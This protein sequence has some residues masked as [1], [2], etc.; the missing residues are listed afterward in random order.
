MSVK[1]AGQNNP[2]LTPKQIIEFGHELALLSTYETQRD[3]ILNFLQ[4]NFESTAYIW[5]KSVPKFSIQNNQQIE[6][7]FDLD[8][9]K[10]E[11]NAG[12]LGYHLIEKN[13]QFWFLS[14]LIHNGI[15]FGKLILKRDNPFDNQAVENLNHISQITAMEIYATLQAQL[16][17]W[18]QKQLKLVRN[19]TEQI[20]LITDLDLL[21][22]QIT[23]LIQQTFN[24]SYVAV[25]LIDKGCE[26]LQFMASAL[27]DEKKPSEAKR[28]NFE[29][30]SHPGFALGEHMI[31]H[32]AKTGKEL[33]ANNVLKEPRYKIVDS[34]AETQSEAV[35][36]LKFTSRILG[37]FDVQSDETNAFGENDLLVLRALADNISIAIERTR[38]YQGVKDQADQ[39]AAVYDVSRAITS[40]LN[41]DEL[42]QRIVNLIHERF[43]FP[44]VH[45]FVIDHVQNKITYK[46]GSGHR[47]MGYAKAGVSFDVTAEKGILPWVV[48]HSETMLI[49][50]IEAEPLFIKSYESQ[51][52]TGS[53]MAIP[54][55][56]GGEILGVLD[57]QS[58]QKDAFTYE[59]Q[60]LMETLSDNIAIALRNAGLY[61]SENW[62]RKVAESLRDVAGLLSDNTALSDIL[63]VILIRLR[64]NLPCDSAVFWLFDPNLTGETLPDSQELHL[65]AYQT[66]EDL[67]TQSLEE[68]TY[69]P[70]PWVKKAIN[71]TSPTIRQHDDVIG[72]I[73]NKYHLPQNYSAI[74]APL[75]TGEEIL[76][77]L[78]LMHRTPG[79]YGQE[80]QKITSAFASYAAIAIK[81][82]RL[83]TTSQEQAWIAT[84]LLQVATATQSLTKLDELVT[85]IVRLTPMVVGVKG[86]A[87]FLREPE[88]DVF[89]L[90]AFYGIGN[91]SEGLNLDRPILLTTSPILEKLLITQ[92]PQR[93]IDPKVDFDLPDSFTD[94]MSQDSLMLLPLIVR[95]EILGA[96]MLACEPGSHLFDDSSV[97]INEEQY[98]IIQGIIQQTAIAI[99]NIRLLEAKQEEAYI[100]TVLLQAAQAAVSS[101]DLRDTLESIVHIMPI[102]VGIDASVIYIWNQEENCFHISHA[103]ISGTKDE[104]EIMD[105][106]YSPGDFPMLDSVFQNNHPVVFPFIDNPLPPEDWDLALPDEE[107]TDPTP[108][109]QSRY[110]L[111]MGFP[112]SMKDDKFG[113]LLA[114]DKSFSA[115]RERRF[116]LLWGIAQQASLAI[117]NDIIKNEMIERQHLEREFQL[118]REIQQTFLPNQKPEIPGWEMDVRWET[119]RLVGG[120]FY[121]YFLLPDGRLA[122]LIADVSDKGLAA[123]LYMTV[124]RTLIRAAAQESTSPSET[125]ERVNDL[126]LV[127]SQNG[128]FVTTFYG[129][130]SMEDGT[131]KYTIAGHNPPFLIKYQENEVITFSK[132]GIALGALPDIKLQQ[133]QVTLDPGDCLILYTDG[134]TEAF[135]FEDQMYGEKR[136]RQ[137]LQKTVG[138]RAKV[139]LENLETDLNGFRGSAPLS[140][141]TTMLAISRSKSLTNEHRDTST[142]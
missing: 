90:N 63:N 136:L 85:T 96:F 122:F 27:A 108:V 123:A 132:G 80:S 83:Y 47:A 7:P 72:P 58:D 140:D 53:E 13:H 57:I 127:N 115:N 37:V 139:V 60:Q 125:L 84:I 142:P 24:Y 36:P 3:T 30:E 110:P 50:D 131:L 73:A 54:L 68:L 113:V 130:L 9:E 33:I 5:L 34:L 4:S 20:S 74:A 32:V 48:R 43:E 118:A 44:F 134:V 17:E 128:L 2:I 77:I 98:Q 111:L 52:T 124:T 70:D 40:I 106:D 8:D 61:R 19:V 55:N 137:L 11:S 100:S 22:K 25:F 99:E 78:M 56:F 21:T 91:S 95:D 88:R 104:T 103:V 46:A 15:I 41:N 69:S 81:N 26:R 14:Q 119:A 71:Q 38:L 59:A 42:L 109:L 31:G 62:R 117:Q 76:G 79:R 112:L 10:I 135:N 66:A 65:A 51:Q 23:K 141:D 18:R 39:L 126:L 97:I 75:R 92:E 82:T 121:D 94:Q 6:L 133:N 87:L 35:I 1:R 45:L 138:E 107:Q 28:P 114:L 120:D 12:Q 86:C 116:E 67:S 29:H 64:Q 49:N 102:L 93:V 101:S 105:L 16:T 89:S 129:I